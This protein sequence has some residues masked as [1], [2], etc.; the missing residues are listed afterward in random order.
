MHV[1]PD[2]AVT[3]MSVVDDIAYFETRL[4]FGVVP[5][6]S[7]FSTVSE[8]IFDLA[9]DILQDPSWD[10]MTLHAPSW[11]TFEPPLEYDGAL[12][13]GKAKQLAVEIPLQ[14]CLCDGYI[15]DGI[16]AAVE[17]GN[18]ALRLA[19]AGP[20]AVHTVIAPVTGI[21]DQCRE[22]AL[23]PDKLQA[24]LTPSEI[25]LTLG[26]IINTRTF[27]IHLPV[28]KCLDWTQ[29]IKRLISNGVVRADELHTT[30]G[31]LNHVGYI[32]PMGPY[33]LNRLRYR[34]HKCEQHGRQKLAR[35]DIEDLTLWQAM[36][37]K[38]AQEGVDINH[39][40]YVEPTDVGI[41]DAC[42]TGLGGFVDDGVAWRWAIPSDMLGLFSINLLEFIAAVVKIW[43]LLL[44][45]PRGRTI[46][47]FTDNSSALGWLY[48]AS[49][50]PVTHAAHD[51][52]ARHLA[53]LLLKHDATLYSQHIKGSQNIVADSLSRD[54]HLPNNVLLPLLTSVF[55]TQVPSNMRMTIL[56]KE[57]VSWLCSLKQT[58]VCRRVA[59]QVRVPS[60][61]GV[62]AATYVSTKAQECLTLS[63][64]TARRHRKYASCQNFAK[65][66][67]KICGVQ[68]RSNNWQQARLNPHLRTCVRPFGRTIGG[69]LL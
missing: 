22:E 1:R 7:V 42:E 35:W 59:L 38:A 5:G 47:N 25:K 17:L 63:L 68:N 51:T 11:E 15:D 10:P 49:F 40:T 13:F 66:L 60:S 52:V 36:L 31:R 62:L 24:E 43:L 44:R 64:T 46:L 12:P 28:E 20:L 50:N 48:K 55:P 56:P 53:T 67:D 33:F 27:R 6:P 39:V 29:D 65:V 69:A 9:N 2:K 3:S 32:M 34:L 16:S 45:C 23:A 18:N 58:L 41:T 8:A 30:I 14:E 4:P 54:L 26:W 19:N 37:T 21:N 61:L 57:I